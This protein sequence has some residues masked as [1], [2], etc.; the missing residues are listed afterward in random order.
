MLVD[1]AVVKAF[2]PL[3]AVDRAEGA[4]Q[5]QHLALVADRLRHVGAGDVAHAAIVGADDRV[6]PA[7]VRTDVDRDDRHLLR[8][9]EIERRD[10]RL[11]VVRDDDQSLGSGADQVADVGDLLAGILVGIG[12][13]QRVQPRGLGGGDGL[14]LQDDLELRHQKRRRISD[15]L[16]GGADRVRRCQAYEHRA[17]GRRRKKSGPPIKTLHIFPPSVLFGFWKLFA[18]SKRLR[19]TSPATPPFDLFPRRKLV[20]GGKRFKN[21]REECCKRK[22]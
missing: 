11:A 14:V 21:G 2:A 13:R 16:A 4:L 8:G 9:R 22:R 1:D 15:R 6:E 5:R 20:R 18:P 19:S 12:R 7:A 10:D 3:A 17:R